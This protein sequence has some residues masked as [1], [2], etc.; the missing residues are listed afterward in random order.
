MARIVSTY[1]FR[2]NL[3]DYLEEVVEEETPLV[4]SRFGNPIVI[5]YPYKEKEI[6]DFDKYFGFLGGDEDGVSFENR[7]RRSKREKKRVESLR[8]GNG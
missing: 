5:V 7:I 8:R 6:E 3:S 2:S 1:K 4:V